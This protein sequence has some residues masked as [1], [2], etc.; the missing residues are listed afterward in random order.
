MFNKKC[1]S[2][3]ERQDVFAKVRFFLHLLSFS[4][5]FFLK[6]FNFVS[7]CSTKQHEWF[8]Q[9]LDIQYELSYV[10]SFSRR[11]DMKTREKKTFCL[12]DCTFISILLKV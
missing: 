4:S 2:S 9:Q 6:I 12:L 1:D 8:L 11:Q 10:L 7:S 3:T 5:H